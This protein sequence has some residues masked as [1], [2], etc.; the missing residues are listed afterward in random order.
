ME[1]NQDLKSVMIEETPWWRQA[2]NESEARRNVGILFDDN[3][4]NTETGAS[5]KKLEEMQ[6]GDG[7]WPWP[8]RLR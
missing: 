8:R 3:R 6:L 4:L 5:L 7:R 2:K 1:K